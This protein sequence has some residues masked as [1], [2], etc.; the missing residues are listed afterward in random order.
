[1][2]ARPRPKGEEAA[3]AAAGQRRERR[4][5]QERGPPGGWAG[6]GA[7]PPTPAGRAALASSG[8]GGGG[9]PPSLPPATPEDA[10][11]RGGG[12]LL[13]GSRCRRLCSARGCCQLLQLLLCTL[14]VICSSVSYNSVGGYTGLFSL[15]SIYY[16]QYGGAYSG[17]SGADG[18]RAQQL[19]AQF[20][21]LK[22]P[23]AQTAMAVGGGLMALAC[24]LLG[25]GLWGLAWRCPPWLIAEAFLEG[26]AALGLGPGLYFYYHRLQTA[27]SS[28]LCR[29][30][31]SLYHSK[32][33]AG[34]E[35]SLHGA[36]I[37]VGLFTGAAIVAFFVG[38]GL[39]VRAFGII[40]ELQGKPTPMYEV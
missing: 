8:G 29:E 19:D 27:Y 13:D 7:T 32:G 12:G 22:R 28:P 24:L 11:R 3:A 1:M 23:P 10:S 33:Y 31:Q 14:T 15:G 20:S 21:R 26:A 2:A 34:F 25:A 16:Y 37:A 39:A 6:G 5:Q 9:P 17:F 4:G 40:R 38:A 18:E 35:C 30:R 36:E